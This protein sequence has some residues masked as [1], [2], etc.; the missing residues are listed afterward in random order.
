M[1]DNWWDEGTFS[2]SHRCCHRTNH[3]L[4]FQAQAFTCSSKHFCCFPSPNY[5]MII[6]QVEVCRDYTGKVSWNDMDEDWGKAL[7]ESYKQTNAGVAAAERL[8]RQNLVRVY[9]RLPEH[10]AVE[11]HHREVPPNPSSR[12]PPM[13]S[14]MALLSARF[15]PIPA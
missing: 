3:F 6:W 2:R 11:P 1:G 4:G 10:D 14:E 5:N 9:G 13:S 7:T 15:V 12:G 8:R